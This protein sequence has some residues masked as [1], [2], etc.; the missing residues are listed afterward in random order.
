MAAGNGLV[1]NSSPDG[2]CPQRALSLLHDVAVEVPEILP[3]LA[4]LP[5]EDLAFDQS[6]IAVAAISSSVRGALTVDRRL[7]KYSLR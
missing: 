2:L 5:E 7:L 6:A 4:V 3:C 1:R